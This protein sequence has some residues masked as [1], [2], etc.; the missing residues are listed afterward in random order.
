MAR[1]RRRAWDRYAARQAA[2][3]SA[4]SDEM[5]EFVLDAAGT[6]T[7]AAIVANGARIAVKHG[8]SSAALACVFYDQMA[9]MSGTE[10]EKAV[11]IVIAN[12]GRI[13]A[14]VDK[15]APML[16][17]GDLDGFAK[18]CGDAVANEV[19]RS[20]SRTMLSNAKRDGA[21]FA[22]VPQGSETCAFCISVASNGW[23]YARK[24][25]VD[26][27]A[28]HIHPNCECEFCVRF[29]SETQVAGYDPKA[30]EE[31]YK[32]AD[33]KNSKDKIN[34]IRRDLYQENKDKINEQHR[35]RYAAMHSD[36]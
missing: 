14:L 30:Y 1:L 5:S 25:T 6:P 26:N 36:E 23:T 31:T 27:H 32:D 29:D 12:T 34:S 10:I 24:G 21:Q 15:A 16:E 8:R 11:P 20:A 19:K 28:D 7:R 3:R 4:A 33:G 2:Q 17:A 22:W 35:E 18:A 9:R 13:G